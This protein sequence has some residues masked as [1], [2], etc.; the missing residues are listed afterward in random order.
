[1][2]RLH[3]R[4]LRWQHAVSPSEGMSDAAGARAGDAH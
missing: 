3:A 2:A 4:R 1:M